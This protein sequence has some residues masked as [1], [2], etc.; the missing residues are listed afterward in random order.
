[1]WGTGLEIVI[2]RVLG[3]CISIGGYRV[4]IGGVLGGKL[5]IIGRL[6]KIEGL[7]T[8]LGRCGGAGRREKTQNFYHFIPSSRVSL[9]CAE[10]GGVSH[11]PNMRPHQ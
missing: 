8:L 4:V 5:R 3:G 10:V 1:M 11:G 9:E 7:H 2:G 6:L